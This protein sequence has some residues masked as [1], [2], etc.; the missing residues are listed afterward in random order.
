MLRNCLLISMFFAFTVMTGSPRA[1]AEVRAKL[2]WFD[3]KGEIMDLDWPTTFQWVWPQEKFPVAQ[4]M[5]TVPPQLNLVATDEI[6][7]KSSNHSL[8]VEM[9]GPRKTIKLKKLDQTDDAKEI[10][11]TI[12]LV[13]DTSNIV[14]SPTCAQEGISI[15]PRQNEASFL[16][17][18]ASCKQTP[19]GLRITLQTSND[20][21]LARDEDELATAHP[22]R[23]PLVILIPKK[24]L[25]LAKTEL[26]LATF[27]IESISRP[28]V[29]TR[30]ELIY[31]KDQPE[32]TVP[33]SVNRATKSTLAEKEMTLAPATSTHAWKLL[34]GLAFD[35]L[36]Y[37]QVEN[38]V[39]FNPSEL[40]LVARLSAEHSIFSS[41]IWF[42]TALEIPLLT[43]GPNTHFSPSGFYQDSTRVSFKIFDHGD[44]SLRLEPG[45]EMNVAHFDARSDRSGFYYGP[46]LGADLAGNLG[47]LG[48]RNLSALLTAAVLAGKNAEPILTNWDIAL[49]LA[50]EMVKREPERSWDLV[51]RLRSTTLHSSDFPSSR[52]TET[53]FG[54]RTGF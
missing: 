32:I 51:V 52:S 23:D 43:L 37:S 19:L 45:I 7:A 9:D 39:G 53:L 50:L 33:S 26:L 18:A 24:N 17:L 22:A 12:N 35:Y 31:S 27:R 25:E 8:V 40:N 15:E 1:F 10:G 42:K 14:A 29:T 4:L 36:S 5:I 41:S 16:F 21:L 13:T 6:Q 46:V 3:A 30:F 48:N 54:V 38:T 34:A 47:F 2:Q 20:A 11:I 44:L 28:Q 49:E